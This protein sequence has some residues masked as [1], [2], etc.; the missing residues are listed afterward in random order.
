MR[1]S[2]RPMA[3]CL[4]TPNLLVC[5]LCVILAVFPVKTH[6]IRLLSVESVTLEDVLHKLSAHNKNFIAIQVGAHIGFTAND[7]VHDLAIQYNWSGV[8]LEP[9]PQ[10]YEKLVHNYLSRWPSC[11]FRFENAAIGATTGTERFYIRKNADFN[12][13]EDLGGAGLRTQMGSLRRTFGKKGIPV[14]VNTITVQDLFRKHSISHVDYLQIDA[15]GMDS[16]VVG[17]VPFDRIKPQVIQYERKHLQHAEGSETVRTL[18]LHGYVIQEG[19]PPDFD[20][21]AVHK[22]AW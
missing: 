22:D 9:V 20:V 5:T 10:L 6:A 16:L 3:T 2:P 19:G 14:T 1:L 8:L 15:E 13:A 21:L 12:R 17:Q 7:P 18:R 4:W 11:P